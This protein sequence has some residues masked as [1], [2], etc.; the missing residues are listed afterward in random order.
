MKS[1]VL[2]KHNNRVFGSIEMIKA[3]TKQISNLKKGDQ[4]FKNREKPIFANYDVAH[5]VLRK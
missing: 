3:F 2:V 5:Q 4:T 1:F